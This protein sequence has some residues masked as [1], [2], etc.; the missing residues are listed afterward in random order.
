MPMRY[1]TNRFIDP[2]VA[3]KM[4]AEPNKMLSVI[5]H[6]SDACTHVHQC[7]ESL[8]G[9]V[10][11]VLP[12]IGA[13]AAEI[14]AS[15]IERLSL[16]HEVEYINHDSNVFKCMDVASL[17]V[18]SD[19]VNESG[20]TG[21]GIGVAVIDTGVINH[22]DFVRPTN[23]IVAFKDFVNG[24]ANPYDDDGHGTHVAGIIA[25]N[26]F[27][28]EDYKGI[29]PEAS[30]IG[31]KVLDENGSGKTSDI[32]AGLQWVIDTKDMYNTKVVCM[33]LGSPAENPYNKDPLAR[34]VSAAVQQGLTV[35]VA[36]G[37]SGPERRTITS[38]GISP[39]AITVGATDD[40]R[41][42]TLEDD[43]IAK[44]SGRGPTIDGNV[45]PDVVA[46]GV[47]IMSCS[48]KSPTSYV[49]Y[50]GT[51]MAAP[52]VAGAA[53][54]LYQKYPNIS[55]A[56]V[57]S[58]LV[59][60]A[61]PIDRSPYNQGA[62]CIRIRQAIGVEKKENPQQQQPQSPTP[63]PRQ[64]QLPYWWRFWGRGMFMLLQLIFFI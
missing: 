62:G 39:S 21:K 58:R 46:P 44:F 13:V 26:G 48:Y 30:I 51:S 49:A 23:R 12:L 14:P 41:T 47:D 6:S 22:D 8:G 53:V 1:T 64:R 5:V 33:S 3:T 34:A 18:E 29:A 63:H 2:V 59:Q 19:Y 25:G 32:L 24:R 36:A 20:Y 31:V 11:Y 55:P 38:P 40:N 61:I 9:K 35:V 7:I 10:K 27:I 43:F 45:K 60:S 42:V 4:S 57:K 50:S 16:E 37:N 54:L 17:A 52:I 56:E 15:Q 28:K